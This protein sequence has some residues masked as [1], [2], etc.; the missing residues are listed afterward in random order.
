MAF[1]HFQLSRYKEL[2]VVA[3]T[4]CLHHTRTPA[5]ISPGPSICLSYRAIP[6]SAH[7]SIS[8]RSPLIDLLTKIYFS[9]FHVVKP[10]GLPRV[11]PHFRV[12]VVQPAGLPRVVPHLI[13]YVVQPA[14]L[15][16]GCITFYSRVSSPAIILSS[17][18][19]A[20]LI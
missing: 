17:S 5:G 11:V 16:P 15:P 19:K 8:W 3:T 2:S 14:G 18:Q 10:A 20:K 7:L 13:V 6:G 4:A 1:K 9:K 12:Y